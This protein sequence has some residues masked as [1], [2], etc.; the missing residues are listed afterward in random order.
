MMRPRLALVL[1]ALLAPCA[2]L[3][4]AR[5]GGRLLLPSLATLAVYPCMALLL[6]AGRP[7]RAVLATLLWAASLSASIIALA[8]RDPDAV[9]RIVLHGP[10][11]REEMFAFI[12]QGTGPEGDP[13]RFLP[14]H[15]VH[16]AAFAAFAAASGG[17]L[18]LASGSVLIGY[19]SYYVGCLV[20]AGGAPWRAFLLGWPPYAVIRVIGYV[21]LGIALSRPILGRIARRPLAWTPG[22]SW[23]AAAATLL[24]VDALLK[25]ALAPAWA[26]LLR[27][28]LG[29]P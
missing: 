4:A 2:A 27:P 23:Y 9:G 3:V 29:V 17:L 11:Y 13:A 22:R 16:L 28:C 10:A 20:A 19:M 15:F 18:G 21:L 8:A 25:W 12:R 6:T 7:R 24:L 14:Q 1:P 26:A 5:A